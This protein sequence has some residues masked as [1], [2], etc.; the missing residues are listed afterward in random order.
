MI[1]YTK[2][3]SLIAEHPGAAAPFACSAKFFQN[4]D[5]AS[6]VQIFNLSRVALNKLFSRLYL[7]AHENGEYL[8]GMVMVAGAFR[9]VALFTVVVMMVMR[10]LV[11]VVMMFIMVMVVFVMLVLMLMLMLM[12]MAFVFMSLMIMIVSL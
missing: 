4:L 11:V 8:V 3:V 9:I 7:I 2:C 5:S 1:F 10:V 12:V 6:D